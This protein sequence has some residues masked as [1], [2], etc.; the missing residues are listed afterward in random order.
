MV[1]NDFYR[2][3]VNFEDEANKSSNSFLSDQPYQ[4]QENRDINDPEY[5]NKKVDWSYKI[6]V[7]MKEQECT[8]C[9]LPMAQDSNQQ[10]I[11][12]VDCVKTPCGH[13]FHKP[14]LL[15]WMQ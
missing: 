6:L 11:E 1:G 13:R 9:M 4:R 3:E 2:Y 8:I 12:L 7:R 15:S 10:E 14:C 5:L